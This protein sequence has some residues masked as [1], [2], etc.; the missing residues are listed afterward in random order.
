MQQKTVFA[1]FLWPPE[2]TSVMTASDAVTICGVDNDNR[3][4]ALYSHCKH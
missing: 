4:S 2:A 3:G 1:E